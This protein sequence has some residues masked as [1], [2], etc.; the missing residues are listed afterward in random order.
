V[1]DLLESMELAAIWI[2]SITPEQLELWRESKVTEIR[3]DIRKA[4]ASLAPVSAQQGAA[5]QHNAVECDSALRAEPASQLDAKL[6]AAIQWLRNAQHGDNCFL[7]DRYDGDMRNCCNCGKD[8]L[9]AYLEDEAPAGQH[10]TS[11]EDYRAGWRDGMQEA[12]ELI[13]SDQPTTPEDEQWI[14]DLAAKHESRGTELFG[15]VTFSSTALVN[16]TR[17]VKAELATRC[18]AEGGDTSDN[19]GSNLAA[20]APAVQAVD[21]AE[22]SAERLQEIARD[23]EDAHTSAVLAG[24]EVGTD[25]RNRDLEFARNTM[26]S[27]KFALREYAKLL[28]ASPASAPEAAPEQQ[29]ANDWEEDF[30]H[31]NGQY[32][33]R[34]SNCGCRFIGHKR[35]CVCK[36]CYDRAAPTAGAATTS[37][38][39]RDAARLAD[40]VRD[41]IASHAADNWPMKKYA[42]EDIEKNIR[43]INVGYLL[44]QA[45]R[46]TQQEGE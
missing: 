32:E 4:R 43:A 21:A 25:E 31:E 9:L 29:L 19:S 20:K 30:K 17:D 8:S 18:R 15:P 3:R 7:T 22:F 23:L 28:A 14:F 2:E 45:M 35:R 38:D 26:V 33:G 12:Q 42:L 10:N 5:E 39:A 40:R 41:L 16:F 46:A 24:E 37:E 6:Q 34:C 1:V 13:F 36:A 27:A 11:S 44:E